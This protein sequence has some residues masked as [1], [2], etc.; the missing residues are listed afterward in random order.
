MR[1][2]GSGNGICISCGS[3]R[4][5]NFFV[6]EKCFECLACC[7]GLRTYIRDYG[8]SDN[9]PLDIYTLALPEPCLLLQRV[10]SVNDGD[11][12]SSEMTELLDGR[13]KLLACPWCQS[14][15]W[16]FRLEDKNAHS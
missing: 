1:V 10:Y 9:G 5:P 13:P 12:Y 11:G 8:Y 15:L 16:R 6:G 3:R 7:G 2:D 4:A 14:P